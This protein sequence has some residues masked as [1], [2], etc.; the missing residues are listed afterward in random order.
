MKDALRRDIF[1][2]QME[3]QSRHWTSAVAAQD[4]MMPSA[5]PGRR[6]LVETQLENAERVANVVERPGSSR[7]TMAMASGWFCLSW[8]G[9]QALIERTA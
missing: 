8:K 1:A 4:V 3:V 7:I 9:H 6:S 2:C 5:C